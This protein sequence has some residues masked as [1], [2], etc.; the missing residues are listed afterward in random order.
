METSLMMYYVPELVLPLADAG[1]GR[2]RRAR[3]TGMRDGWVW[4]PRPWTQVTSDTGVGNPAAATPE[5]GERF[6]ADL[7]DRLADFLIE[8][9]RANPADLYG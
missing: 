5:K 7:I 3:L 1:P 8:L 2:A 6:T 4:A 9:S